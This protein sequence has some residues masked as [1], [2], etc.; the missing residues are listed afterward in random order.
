MSEIKSGDVVSSKDKPN[1]LMTVEAVEVKCVYFDS[2]NK[3][4][5]EIHNI[6][7]ILPNPI[8]FIKSTPREVELMEKY[9]DKPTILSQIILGAYQD[10]GDE[11]YDK[12]NDKIK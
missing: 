3:L 10:I 11:G 12:L 9:K 4:H 6:T 5:R 7:D 2:K 8:T 1:Q